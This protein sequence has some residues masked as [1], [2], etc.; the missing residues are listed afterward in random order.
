MLS[1]KYASTYVHH[2]TL[3]HSIHTCHSKI[4]SYIEFDA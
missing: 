2:P 3:T 1:M 4:L